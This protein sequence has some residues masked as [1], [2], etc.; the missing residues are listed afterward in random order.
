M[1]NQIIKI[2]MHENGLISVQ[3]EGTR[4]ELSSMLASA[5]EG[6]KAF[7]EIFTEAMLKL[8][9]AQEMERIEEIKK[10]NLN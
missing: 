5:I 9:A 2:K 7:N 8:V 4:N 10:A 6:D 1:Q 3:I